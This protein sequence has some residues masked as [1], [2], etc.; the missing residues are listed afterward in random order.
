M[1]D[2]WLSGVFLVFTSSEYS[3]TRFQPELRPR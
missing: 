1:T 3:K 2:L